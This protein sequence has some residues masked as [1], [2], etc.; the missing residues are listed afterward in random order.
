M[1]PRRCAARPAA[2]RPKSAK[3]RSRTRSARSRRAVH[4]AQCLNYTEQREHTGTGGRPGRLKP[5]FTCRV[6]DLE[7]GTWEESLR[8][9]S[10]LSPSL[11]SSLKFARL[12][13]SALLST[14]TRLQPPENERHRA[15]LLAHA[16]A[17][18]TLVH[19]R[20][21]ARA[22]DIA[23]TRRDATTVPVPVA[24]HGIQC[25]TPVSARQAAG[26]RARGESQV[27]RPKRVRSGK[28]Q[29]VTSI[30]G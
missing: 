12:L 21:T 13:C 16:A 15:S 5:L 22:P 24:H 6:K 26:T 29:S 7:R 25:D 30:N 28:P 18:P 1:C 20:Y 10:E 23:T 19:A 27:P 3:A 9:V 11:S 2:T 4:G 17:H 8:S 14:T